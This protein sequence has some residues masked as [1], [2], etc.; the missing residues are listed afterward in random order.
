LVLKKGKNVRVEKVLFVPPY[1][2]VSVA[3]GRAKKKLNI[4]VYS[5]TPWCLVWKFWREKPRAEMCPAL[6]FVVE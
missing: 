2:L 3:R 6:L 4:Y 5:V 1:R